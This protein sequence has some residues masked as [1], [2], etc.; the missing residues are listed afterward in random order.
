[1]AFGGKDLDTLFITT[2]KK[3]LTEEQ[4]AKYP[5]AGDLFTVK[6]GVRGMIE[7]EYLG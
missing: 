7:P 2:G 3:G 6:P 5:R 4:L 1:M